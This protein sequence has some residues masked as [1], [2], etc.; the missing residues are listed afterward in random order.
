MNGRTHIVLKLLDNTGESEVLICAGSTCLADWM[1]GEPPRERAIDD[2]SISDS[3]MLILRASERS[4]EAPDIVDF[5]HA[6]NSLDMAK[7][8]RSIFSR[9]KSLDPDGHCTA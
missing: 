8:L 4:P 1:S 2:Y 3:T 7:V 6:K 9:A 5:S